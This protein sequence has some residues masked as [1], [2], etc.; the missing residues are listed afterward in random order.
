MT[1]PVDEATVVGDFSRGTTLSA[2][3]RSYEFGMR[4][5]KPVVTV[6]VVGRPAESFAVDDTLGSKRLRGYWSTLPDGRIYVLPA[7]WHVESRRWLDWQEATPIPDGAHDLKQIWNVNGFMSEPLPE[8]DPQGEF[9]P[10]GRPNRFNRTQALA[11]SGCFKAGAA[12]CTSSH[13]AHGSTNHE[14]SLM[15]RVVDDARVVRVRAAESLLALNVVTAPGR[16]GEALG[17]AQVELIASLRAFPESA[18]LQALLAW[19]HAQRGELSEAERAVDVAL[20]LDPTLARPYVVRGV[21]QARAGKFP[22]AIASWKA[23][24]DRDP[25]TPNL[26]Q[27][28]DAASRRLAAPPRR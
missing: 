11:L 20:A 1:R 14:F 28:I 16:A 17:R 9:W 10:D 2:E 24:R 27:M 26:Q 25:T 12:T 19:L 23:A 18:T 5:G 15:A 4:A 8:Y 3:G 7:F 21:L 13:L 22:E 6:R